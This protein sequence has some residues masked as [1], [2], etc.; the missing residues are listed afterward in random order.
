MKFTQQLSVVSLLS[1]AVFCAHA[2]VASYVSAAIS[3]PHRAHDAEL[4]DRRHPSELAE[5]A[6]IKPGDVV[7]DL[8][9][10]GGY[11][12]RI[13]SAIVGPRGHVYAIWPNEYARVDGDEV[14][15]TRA[16]SKDPHY[17]NVTVLMQPA[18]QFT[19]PVKADLVWISQNLHDYP[20][21]FMG[22]VQPAALAGSILHSLKP[23]GLLVVVDHAAEYGSG[24]RDTEK[25]HRI[26]PLIVQS[27]VESAGFSLDGESTVLRNTSDTHR[28][29]V[30][31]PAVRGRTDQFVFRFRAPD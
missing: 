10:G 23:H 2:E 29:V 24:M 1:L 11:F 12:T 5:F 27:Q 21:R 8:V 18:A 4:D 28:I 16:L 19:V 22:S 25:T 3:D 30:F 31:N 9:P 14:R 13:F 7:V 6:R 15:A 17:S 20:D 26:D